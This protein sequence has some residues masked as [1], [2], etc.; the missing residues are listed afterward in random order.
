MIDPAMRTPVTNHSE[1]IAVPESGGTAPETTRIHLDSSARL[2]RIDD[3][4]VHLSPVELRLLEAFVAQ[5]GEVLT[6]EQLHSQVWGEEPGPR[7]NILDVY[8]GRLRRKLDDELFQ[9]IHGV[10]YRMVPH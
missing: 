1:R 5:I 6:R 9:T 3:R 10:G 4:A 7:S 2:A 8:V